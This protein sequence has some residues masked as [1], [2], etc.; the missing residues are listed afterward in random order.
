MTLDIGRRAAWNSSLLAAQVPVPQPQPARLVLAMG[1]VQAG[2]RYGRMGMAKF[3]VRLIS[4]PVTW[5]CLELGKTSFKDL[6]LLTGPPGSFLFQNK[7]NIFL[8]L[9]IL[10]SQVSSFS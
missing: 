7:L 1:G 5:E 6:V 10:P 2:G 9:E 4:S 8:S 3:G